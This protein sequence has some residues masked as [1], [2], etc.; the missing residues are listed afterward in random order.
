MI[1]GLQAI[2]NISVVDSMVAAR[3]LSRTH[4]SLTRW[5]A[6]NAGLGTGH[7]VPDA[8][9][10]REFGREVIIAMADLKRANELAAALAQNGC[11]VTCVSTG[12][13][14]V[15]QLA[16]AILGD[17]P[18]RPDLIVMGPKLVGCR[19]LTVLAGLRELEWTTPFLLL[20]DAPSA[21]DWT[22]TGVHVGAFE[23]FE[24]RRICRQALRAMGV[25]DRATRA[26][27]AT[28]ELR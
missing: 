17:S 23:P 10:H 22:D 6:T 8:M 3:L 13:D 1:E 20:V 19:E 16:D 7:A 28:V 14:L 2:N 26:R 24:V 4:D 15:A 21:N 25:P 5:P 27:R 18:K 11:T 12:F 9:N